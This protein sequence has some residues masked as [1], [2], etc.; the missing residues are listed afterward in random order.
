MTRPQPCLAQRTSRR[1]GF[2]LLEILVCLAILGIAFVA[3]I[4]SALH[5]QDALFQSRFRN[6]ASLLGSNK[7]AEIRLQGPDNITSWRGRFQEHPQ[8]RWSVDVRPTSVDRLQRVVLHVYKEGS[9]RERLS[10]EE[11][12]LDTEVR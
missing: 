2:T 4:K 8:Y 10:F 1:A 12:V 7:I 11:F 9:E 6:T 5:V 3:V